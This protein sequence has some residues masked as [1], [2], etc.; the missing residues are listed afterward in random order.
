MAD[1]DAFLGKA[2]E[3][4]ESA[5]DDFS[6][7]RFNACAR[8]AY[9]AAFQA[10]VA[11]L[12]HEGIEPRGRWGHEFVQ[13]QFAGMLV[14]RRKLYPARMRG[15]LAEAFQLRT[16]GDYSAR[17]VRRRSV[18]RVLEFARL[19]VRLVKERADGDR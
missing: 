16:E 13:A 11:A 2:E 3:S 14:Y 19:L 7:G 17:M 10:A 12:L 9:Y 6:A 1:A 4:L 15:D 8:N 5:H 18:S